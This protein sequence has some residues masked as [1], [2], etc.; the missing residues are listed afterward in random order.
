MSL[1]F[2]CHFV[3][4]TKGTFF[5]SAAS[6]A[7]ASLFSIITVMGYAQLMHWSNYRC[8]AI[9]QVNPVLDFDS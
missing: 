2:I 1:A 7:F 6:I 3:I 8:K 9:G 5:I 4:A